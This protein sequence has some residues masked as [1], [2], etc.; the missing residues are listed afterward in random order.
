MS[1]AFT[2]TA[3]IDCYRHTYLSIPILNYQS[4]HTL[5]KSLLHLVLCRKARY[6]IPKHYWELRRSVGHGWFECA[7]HERG[8]NKS[9]SINRLTLC[10][11]ARRQRRMENNCVSLTAAEANP[12]SGMSLSLCPV[13]RWT[14]CPRSVSGWMRVSLATMRLARR[15]SSATQLDIC[16]IACIFRWCWCHRCCRSCISPEVNAEKGK[17]RK[18]TKSQRGCGWA[19]PTLRYSTAH[20]YVIEFVQSCYFLY[21]NSPICQPIEMK[22]AEW[23]DIERRKLIK[24]TRIK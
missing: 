4:H 15:V 8:S 1:W 24:D 9:K 7:R 14:C 23:L 21:L 6:F 18:T 12:K 3:D 13:A 22:P 10:Q 5:P 20:I 2:K 16:Q 11:K 19:Y 17:N